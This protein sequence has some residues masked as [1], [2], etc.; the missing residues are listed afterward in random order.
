MKQ[1][2]GRSDHKP[3]FGV[4]E[5]DTM[6]QPDFTRG[7][8]VRGAAEVHHCKLLLL[9]LLSSSLWMVVVVL[10]VVVVAVMLLLFA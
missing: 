8:V 4:F 2:D 9:L 5:V 1:S 3:V 6:L 7:L 10:M